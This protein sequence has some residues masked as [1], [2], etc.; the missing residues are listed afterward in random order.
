M[1][2]VQGVQIAIAVVAAASTAKAQSDQAKA[3]SAQAEHNADISRNN[4]ILA[5]R[6]ADDARAR[7]E[8]SANQKRLESQQLQGKQ[9]A[10]LA[11]SGVTVDQDSALDLQADTAALGELDAL[12][13]ASNA[14]RE[15]LG[16]E[17]RRSNFEAD[18]SASTASAAN[19]QSVGNVK[20]G[21]ALT[22]G[23]SVV[24]DKWAAIDWEA[25]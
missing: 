14:E 2:V 8:I 20:A 17:A 4:A 11:G 18:V 23:F 24:A 15:A 7:G 5:Q 19:I 6:S 21:A 10:A 16:F 3:Q 12:T 1:T 13:V 22:S 25:N 9:R